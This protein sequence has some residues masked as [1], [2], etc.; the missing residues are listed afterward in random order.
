MNC[1]ACD[2]KMTEHDFGNI[3]VDICDLGCKGIWFDWIELGKL[4]E[5]SEGTG[6][7]LEATLNSPQ[8]KNP[9]RGQIKCPKCYQ[10]MIAHFYQAQNM[11]T[12]D[13]CYGCGGFFLDGGELKVLREHHLTEQER[14]EY[15]K[16]LW[17]SDAELSK[18]HQALKKELE[19]DPEERPGAIKTLVNLLQNTFK[20]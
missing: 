18:S 12:V 10:P 11:V 1:P 2:K 5:T 19:S 20:A 17:A 16:K 14:E 3:K 6:A 7:A 4:D 13:E 15:I 9:S 8:A